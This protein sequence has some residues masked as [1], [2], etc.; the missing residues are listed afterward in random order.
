MLFVA[1]AMS[2]YEFFQIGISVKSLI[3]DNYKTLNASKKMIEALER[4]DSGILLL[5]AGN[6]EEGRTITKSSD[7]LFLSA[8][9]EAKKNITEIN[10]DE[11]IKN[12][13]NAYLVF[14]NIWKHP[15]VGTKREDNTNWYL[16]D[17]HPHLLNAKQEV[18]TLISLNET[19]MYEEATLIKEQSKKA[20][21]PGIIA[22]FSFLIFL[23]LLNFFINLIV[24]RPIKSITNSIRNYSSLS[25]KFTLDLPSNNEFKILQDEIH[26][27]FKDYKNEFKN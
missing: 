9:D 3:D 18:E 11:L 21:M 5:I 8:L 2:I 27:Y 12:I 10:E 24:V 20:I 19:T 17:V 13:E 7:S 15:I 1:G 14:K 16:K 4:E 22:I 6:W 26:Y 25:R 23:I